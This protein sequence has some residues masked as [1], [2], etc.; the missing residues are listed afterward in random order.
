MDFD[1]IKPAV[2]EIRLNEIQQE[3]ILEACRSKKRKSFNYKFWIP[4][5]AAAMFVVVIFSPGFIFRAS[6]ADLSASPEGG[7][8]NNAAGADNKYAELADEEINIAAD[9]YAN[10]VC[11]VQAQ[12]VSVEIRSVFECNGFRSI[13]SVVPSQFAWLVDAEEYRKWEKTVKASDGMAIVQFVEHFKITKEA[14]DS[15]NQAY[16]AYIDSIIGGALSGKPENSGDEKREIFNA[17][18]IY[19]FDREKID[20]YYSK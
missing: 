17:D 19:S 7:N 2:E 8:Y 4:V 3:K 11:S 9:D 5:A 20:E 18:I 16:A 10:E 12:S 1:K 13:Y 15:A 14:F 6:E